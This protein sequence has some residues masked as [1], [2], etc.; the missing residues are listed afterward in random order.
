MFI[1]KHLL[2]II[3]IV[4]FSFTLM[5]LFY[6]IGYSQGYVIESEI[7]LNYPLALVPACIGGLSFWGACKI[8][9]EY[10]EH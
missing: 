6:W 9:E 10:Y 7:L 1:L 4:G 3:S 5:F 2:A 8:E